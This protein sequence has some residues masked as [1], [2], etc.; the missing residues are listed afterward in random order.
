MA[1]IFKA[2]RV[3]TLLD[4]GKTYPTFKDTV[5]LKINYNPQ[6]LILEI[7]AGIFFQLNKSLYYLNLIFLF[8][9]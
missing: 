2:V 1:N 4:N 8:L 9:F 6:G 3:L 5:I 7:E